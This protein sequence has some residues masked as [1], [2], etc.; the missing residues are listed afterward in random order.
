MTLSI[1]G[2]E[3]ALTSRRVRGRFFPGSTGLGWSVILLSNDSSSQTGSGLG[4]TLRAAFEAALADL[5][6]QRSTR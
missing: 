5:D 6:R 2:I 1:D 3:A 4:V